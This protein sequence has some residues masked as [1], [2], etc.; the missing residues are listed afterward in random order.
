LRTCSE[1]EYNP[2]IVAEG[3]DLLVGEGIEPFG[4]D[5]LGSEFF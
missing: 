5:K 3:Y 1:T 2:A 4:A